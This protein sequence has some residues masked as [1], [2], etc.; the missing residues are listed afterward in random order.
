MNTG[1]TLLTVAAV[2]L[3]GTTV[4]T[5]NRSFNSQGMILEQTEVG[6]YAVSLATSIVEQAAGMA[7]DQNTVDNFVTSAGQMS[8]TLGPD[9]TE[10]TTPDSTTNFND[11]DDFN[12]LSMGVPIANV[13]S[14]TVK[15]KV[16]YIDPSNPN[17]SSS[18][19]TTYKRLDVAV[20]GTVSADTVKMSYIFSYYIFR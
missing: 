14:F 10:K 19:K 13:D 12:N 7:F 9:G 15:C 18:S 20:Y 2:V 11:F 4:L 1:Q 17:G 6:I 5:V 3:L 8:S 16:C